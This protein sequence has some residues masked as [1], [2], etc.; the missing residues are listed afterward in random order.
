MASVKSVTE[1]NEYEINATYYIPE[2]K[3]EI[4]DGIK[5]AIMDAVEEFAEYTKTKVGRS[6][7]PGILT[8]YANA[9]GASRIQISSPDFQKIGES[10]VAVCRQIN[11]IFGGFDK[12]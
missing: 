11:V 9:A 1:I 2:E 3:K 12:E 7:N 6:I 10:E 8:A 5:E 4:A